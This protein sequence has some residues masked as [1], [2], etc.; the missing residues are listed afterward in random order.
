MKAKNFIILF[1]LF[2]CSF[3]VRTDNLAGDDS[4]SGL[5]ARLESFQKVSKAL[6]S[7]EIHF[8]AIIMETNRF[9]HSL[10]IKE[11]ELL[12]KMVNSLGASEREKI[13]QLWMETKE[14]KQKTTASYDTI[15]E[16]IKA[17]SEQ[18]R[19]LNLIIEKMENEKN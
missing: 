12:E 9:I 5:Q 16:T 17:V 4:N 1:L 13:K 18:R 6:E 15:M 7:K 2:L 8:Q 19:E 11:E 3:L 14:L 10:Q